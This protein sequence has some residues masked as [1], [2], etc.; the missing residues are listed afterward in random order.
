MAQAPPALATYSP[1]KSRVKFWVKLVSIGARSRTNREQSP[2]HARELSTQG[3]RGERSPLAQQLNTSHRQHQ[4]G[5]RAGGCL[6]GTDPA[7]QP[8]EPAG[9]GFKG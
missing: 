9:D 2:T 3:A 1:H 5:R 7:K 8:Q 4:T 6:A